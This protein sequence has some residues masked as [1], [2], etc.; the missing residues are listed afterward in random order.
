MLVV[1]L[2]N[3]LCMLEAHAVRMQAAG[4]SVVGVLSNKTGQN[5]T[6]EKAKAHKHA[7]MCGKKLDG[8]PPGRRAIPAILFV[9]A[10]L[11]IKRV[12]RHS[13]TTQ[14]SVSTSN[15]KCSMP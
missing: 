14:K 9:R 13:K 11:E 8:L 5:S 12:G 3:R 10:I 4:W 2:I 15:G 7:E 6:H 1:R